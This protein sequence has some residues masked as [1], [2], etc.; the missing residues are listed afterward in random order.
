MDIVRVPFTHPCLPSEGRVFLFALLLLGAPCARAGLLLAGVVHTRTG[1]PVQ[2]A[3]VSWTRE[4]PPA[5][6]D[7]RGGFELSVPDSGTITL[8]V[9]HVGFES[10]QRSIQLPYS[11]R[12]PLQIELTELLYPLGPVVTTAT[13][14]AAEAGRVSS[15]VEAVQFS[16]I[17]LQTAADAGEL[18]ALVPGVVTRSYGALGDVRTL[19]IRGST[20]AQVLVLLDGQRLNQAQTGEVDLSILPMEQVERVEVVRGGTSAQYGADA[21]G[22]VVNIITKQDRTDGAH[23]MVEGT[24]GSFGTRGVRLDGSF[25][26]PG[27]AVSLSYRFLESA[28]DFLFRTQSGSEDVRRNADARS[29]ALSTSAVVGLG[30]AG[31]SLRFSGR[32]YDQHSGDPGMLG[33]PLAKARKHNNDLLADVSYLQPVRSHLV[34]LQAYLH[35]FAFS[36]DDPLASIPIST[37]TWNTAWGAEAQDNLDPAPWL[38]LTAG[39]AARLDHLAGNAAALNQERSTHSLYLQTELATRGDGDDGAVRSSVFPAIRWD[40]FSDFGSTISPK[41][42]LVLSAGGDP[43]VTLKSNAGQSFRAP[44]FNDLY[45]PR[46][47][48]S[49]GNPSLHPERATDIDAGIHV[50]TSFGPG[51]QAG[52]TYFQ[53]NVHDLILWQPGQAGVWK[54]GN[55]GRAFIR[56]IETEVWLGPLT[57]WSEGGIVRFG[58]SY[59]WLDAVDRSGIVNVDGMQLPYRPEHLH[60]LVAEAGSG[61]FKATAELVYMSRRYTTA[62]NTVYLPAC[63]TT[64][65]SLGYSLNIGPGSLQARMLLRNLEDTQYQ[66][67][68]G[69]PLPGREVRFSIRI[70]YGGA[71]GI[72]RE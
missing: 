13:R 49:V 18:L 42:G 16:D 44:T 57:V 22:G 32:F 39:Y 19:S 43:Q 33:F 48:F 10:V 26:H 11:A 60:K 28:G 55:V 47:N 64:D 63:H 29:H 59:T 27:A 17:R 20:S 15:S 51:A 70:E 56:G 41:L 50:R 65:L 58:W 53:N 61:P 46:D 68:E 34:R 52:I 67:A 24:I 45:W 35:R 21:V 3:L 71:E 7:R 12:L 23:G 38:R 36:Y 31:G 6:T 54:P 14:S 69:Y 40:H 62:S 30:D 1:D 8:H 5:I 37:D 72:R 9:R 2:G 25:G 66:M 4:A